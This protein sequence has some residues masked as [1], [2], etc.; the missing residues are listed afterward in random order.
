VP[1]TM[2]LH[3][4]A[5]LAAMVKLVRKDHPKDFAGSRATMFAAQGKVATKVGFEAA[6]QAVVRYCSGCAV[7]PESSKEGYPMRISV[8]MRKEPLAL[9]IA[10]R[11][12]GGAGPTNA[13]NDRRP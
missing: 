13:L 5:Y 4:F 3:S 6:M 2:E 12:H 10:H 7:D 11:P 9:R 1:Q 8:E